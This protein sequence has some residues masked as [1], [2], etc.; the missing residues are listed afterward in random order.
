MLIAEYYNDICTE[1][2]VISRSI[3]C[4]L[5]WN[6]KTILKHQERTSETII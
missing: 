2:V 3:K 6:T 5:F 4:R 1:S